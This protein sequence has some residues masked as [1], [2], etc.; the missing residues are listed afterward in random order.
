MLGTKLGSSGRATST[1]N[2]TL[3]SQTLAF[4]GIKEND[5]IIREWGKQL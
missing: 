5:K 2:P 4:K 1:A 3:L